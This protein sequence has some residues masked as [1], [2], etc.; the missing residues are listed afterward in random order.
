[1]SYAVVLRELHRIHIQL[2]D[3]RER[4]EKGP[5]QVKAHELNV[6]RSE[7][8]A[9][10]LKNEQK[11]LKMASDAKNLQL[12]SGDSK[13]L[14]L[15]TKLNQSKS[16]R[17]YQALKDQIAADQMSGS[18]LQ[19]EIL[20]LEQ[21]IEDSKKVV[22]AAEAVLVKAKEEVNRVQQK[23]RDEQGSLEADFKRLEAQLIESEKGLPDDLRETYTRKV[24]D[25][26]ADCMAVV[27][28]EHCG[29]CYQNLTPNTMSTLMMDKIVQCQVCGRMLYFAEDRS[30]GQ[31]RKRGKK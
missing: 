8:E 18:V 28:G 31:D 27:D 2:G 12:K 1:M 15:K 20:E 16:N 5:R 10:R 26:G 30:I 17:E 4:I 13:M 7:A 9:T 11:A 22:A 6:A 23:V 14:D 25:M 19:D 3:L 24:R 29:G 21:K